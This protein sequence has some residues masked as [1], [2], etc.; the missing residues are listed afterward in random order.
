MMKEGCEEF[1]QP[2]KHKVKISFALM[3]ISQTNP[4]HFTFFCRTMMTCELIT[5]WNCIQ[6]VSITIQEEK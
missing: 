5:M 4:F 6:V 2:A 3:L 1:F